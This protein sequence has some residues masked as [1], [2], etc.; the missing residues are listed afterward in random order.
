MGKPDDRRTPTLSI[1]LTPELMVGVDARVRSGLYTSASELF[2]EALRLFL[3]VEQARLAKLAAPGSTR[4]DQLAERLATTFELFDFGV[5]L[6]VHK[7]RQAE[8]GIGD[9]QI[10][11]RIL[12]AS[13][14]TEGDHVIRSSAE[15]LRQLR[16]EHGP[17]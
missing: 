13:E 12:A 4:D 1:S 16:V 3:Q 17:R 6:Q 11:Q 10:R 7:L 15:R 8:P 14:A 5:A 2:R 9:E